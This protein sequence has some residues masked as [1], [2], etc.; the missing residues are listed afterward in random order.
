MIVTWE[1][2]SSFVK[3]EII[4]ML[5]PSSAL[6]LVGIGSFTGLSS[7]KRLLDG[8]THLA[9]ALKW[10]PDRHRGSSKAIAKEKFKLCSINCAA[11]QSICGKLAAT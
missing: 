5:T 10:H 1:K 7:M 11:Y 6:H 8:R 9:C 4:L 2:V 3:M